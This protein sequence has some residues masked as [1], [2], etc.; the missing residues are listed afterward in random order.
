MAGV[1]VLSQNILLIMPTVLFGYHIKI[2]HAE[3][4]T[5]WHTAVIQSYN[6]NY[7]EL[8][9]LDNMVLE[10]H[11]VDQAIVPLRVIGDRGLTKFDDKFH[12]KAVFTI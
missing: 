4:A 10:E 3:D 8:T 9:M 7:K 1:P 5:Q 12:S 6:S 2:Y 11:K